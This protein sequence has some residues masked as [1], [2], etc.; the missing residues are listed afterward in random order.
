MLYF[1]DQEVRMKQFPD[2]VFP[3]DTLY[4]SCAVDYSGLMAPNFEWYPTPDNILPL[5]DTGTS[6]N[7]TIEVHLTSR[8]VE[9]YTCYVSFDGSVFPSVVNETS[10][11]IYAAGVYKVWL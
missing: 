4:I 2:F 7:S 3:G 1:A 10:T 11:V 5:R 6:V 8:V 9:E